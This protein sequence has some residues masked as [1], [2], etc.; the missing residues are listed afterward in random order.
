MF[1]TKDLLSL[2]GDIGLVPTILL[3]AVALFFLHKEIKKSLSGLGSSLDKLREFTSSSIESLRTDMEA[4]NVSQDERMEELESLLHSS[5]EKL[6]ASTAK[7]NR[8]LR[9]ELEA[10][11]LRQ[12]ARMEVLEKEL[13]F[14]EREYVSKEQHFNDTEGWKANLDSLRRDLAEMPLKMIALIKEIKP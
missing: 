13:K 12:D 2:I 1:G 4:R 7:A 11:N 5:M 3:L 6:H 8:E 10:R 14:I 9:S